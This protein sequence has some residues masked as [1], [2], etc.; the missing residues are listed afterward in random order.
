MMLESI[1]FASARAPE[2]TVDERLIVEPA[3]VPFGV[4]VPFVI[5]IVSFAAL[6]RLGKKREAAGGPS[7]RGRIHHRIT[8]VL[9]ALVILGVPTL[10]LLFSQVDSRGPRVAILV[11]YLVIFTIAAV[12]CRLSYERS[13]ERG[14]FTPSRRSARIPHMGQSKQPC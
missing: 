13:R 5:F 7:M 9:M 8:V 1:A 2:G 3:L 6:Y 11:G 14:A 10:L 4:A 12:L